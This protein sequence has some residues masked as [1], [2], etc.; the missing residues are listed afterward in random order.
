LISDY[1]GVVFGE[2]ADVVGSDRGRSILVPTMQF[3]AANFNKI[4]SSHKQTGNQF[5]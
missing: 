1:G 5:L 2:L 3:V 4:C